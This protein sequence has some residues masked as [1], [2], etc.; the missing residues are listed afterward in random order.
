MPR[1]KQT[2][3]LLKDRYPD[4]YETIINRLKE[5]SDLSTNYDMDNIELPILLKAKKS[6]PKILNIDKAISNLKR[7]MAINEKHIETFQG[8]QIVLKKDIAKMLKISRPTLDKW[9]K[10]G[11]ITPVKSKHF[12]NLEIYPP[13]TVLEQLLKQ[14][15]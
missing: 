10:D 13:A 5:D 11:F 2:K 4:I 6:P 8:E 3:L 9:I 7:Y 15:K 14:K 12:R 1:R